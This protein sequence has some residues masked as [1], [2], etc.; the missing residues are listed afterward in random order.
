MKNKRVFVSGGAGV[1]GRELIPILID[2]GAT[3]LVG[4]L[5]PIPDSYPKNVI[6]RRGDLNH[7]TQQDLNA[8]DP[9]IFIHLAATFER[10]EESYSHWEENF[11]HNLSLSHHLFSLVRNTPSIERVVNASSYLIYDK[12]LY[13]F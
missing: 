8:F 5:Q 10:S 2:E 7:L 1:I 12:S 6:Y 13:Q 9:Q 11:T 3:V 4:D